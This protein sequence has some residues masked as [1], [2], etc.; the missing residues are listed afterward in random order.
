VVA[1]DERGYTVTDTVVRPGTTSLM[2]YER[3]LESCYCVEG[4]GVVRVGDHEWSITAGTL[5]APDRN[6][7]HWLSTDSGLRLVCVFAPALN[8]DERHS[9]DA[10]R[11]SSY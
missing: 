2:R 8:G 6:E 4:E 1:A 3:H 11:P 7:E 9:F 10:N 5:Y